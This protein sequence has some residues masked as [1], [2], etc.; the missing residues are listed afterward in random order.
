MEQDSQDIN[1]MDIS[2]HARLIEVCLLEALERLGTALSNSEMPPTELSATGEQGGHIGH[3]THLQFPDYSFIDK[4]WVMRV[5][6]ESNLFEAV[7]VP[8]IARENIALRLKCV[9][10]ALLEPKLMRDEVNGDPLRSITE[11]IQENIRDH[12]GQTKSGHTEPGT[13][14]S[15]TKEPQQDKK[16]QNE[17]DE[18]QWKENLIEKLFV[19]SGNTPE[20]TPSTSDTQPKTIVWGD[21]VLDIGVLTENMEAPTPARWIDMQQ[22]EISV[23]IGGASY[24]ASLITGLH[25]TPVI[26]PQRE[27]RPNL[28]RSDADGLAFVFQESQLIGKFVRS[29][30]APPQ[31]WVHSNGLGYSRHYSLDVEENLLER[32]KHNGKDADLKQIETFVINYEGAMVY[33]IPE[34]QWFDEINPEAKVIFRYRPGGTQEPHWPLWLFYWL[35]ERSEHVTLIV[36]ADS[37]R[38]DDLVLSANRSW[39][40]TLEDIISSRGKDERHQ[41]LRMAKH[42]VILFNHNGAIVRTRDRSICALKE[43]RERMRNTFKD[44]LPF[45][46]DPLQ[47][48]EVLRDDPDRQTIIRHC[49]REGGEYTLLYRPFDSDRHIRKEAK[50]TF[51]FLSVLAAFVAGRDI[52]G[53]NRLVAEVNSFWMLLEAKVTS[54]ESSNS[55]RLTNPAP[56]APEP[57]DEEW[58]E[59]IQKLTDDDDVVISQAIA[60]NNRHADDPRWRT[61]YVHLTSRDETNRLNAEYFAFLGRVL[62]LSREGARKRGDGE[63][64]ET[65][66]KSLKLSRYQR[67]KW[68]KQL[69]DEVASRRDFERTRSFVRSL[70]DLGNACNAFKI[71]VDR[72]LQNNVVDPMRH[73]WNLDDQVRAKYKDLRLVREKISA[74]QGIAP[75]PELAIFPV[76]KELVH[77]IQAKILHGTPYDSWSMFDYVWGRDPEPLLRRSTELLRKKDAD[78]ARALNSFPH[79]RRTSFK[80]EIFAFAKSEIEELRSLEEAIRQYRIRHKANRDKFVASTPMSILCFGKPGSGKSTAAKIISS[81]VLG[82]MAGEHFVFNLSQIQDRAHLIQQLQRIR[83]ETITGKIPLI[84]FDE[85]DSD[86]EHV[87]YGWLPFFLAPMEDGEFQAGPL[88]HRIGGAIFV[89][90]GSKFKSVGEFEEEVYDEDSQ[91]YAQKGKDFLSR[92]MGRLSVRSVNPGEPLNDDA[93]KLA[94]VFDRMMTIRSMLDKIFP[95]LRL[96]PSGYNLSE[97]LSRALLEVSE[98]KHNKR[99]IRKLLELS[100]IGDR[101]NFD[102]SDLPS[103]AQLEAH[104]PAQEFLDLVRKSVR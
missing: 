63:T 60:D 35:E 80:G 23:R 95:K 68:S 20:E 21:D 62:F 46:S 29:G 28:T 59:H 31:P 100:S 12:S 57:S 38:E 92:V 93:C 9:F 43:S 91:V 40:R 45:F 18:H 98:Y 47:L 72:F 99:S 94:Y 10:G 39:D 55:P 65:L 64:A 6:T 96:E 11:A 73:G 1:G 83:D 90:I 56:F 87:P 79:Y 76:P 48:R 27:P 103:A 82:E 7:K 33:R 88:N 25:G 5:A 101:Q 89:F 52:D 66:T 4:T 74:E 3:Q 51:G 41:F 22:A 13:D 32:P 17:P 58:L 54:G 104:V 77:R 102:R 75:P 81:D 15:N 53:H 71:E 14:D 24:V 61:R 86:L 67:E 50:V 70:D 85:F 97:P 16:D 30:G 34:P 36:H 19:S 26:A 44:R 84:I 42:L 78:L 2:T 37:L 69:L 8:E 49:N